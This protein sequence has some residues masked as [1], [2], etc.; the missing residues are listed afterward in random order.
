MGTESG[1]VQCGARGLEVQDYDSMESGGGGVGGL[2]PQPWRK[3]A[4]AE[5]S[6][7]S[8]SSSASASSSS[9]SSLSSPS[10]SPSNPPS[11]DVT[12]KAGTFSSPPILIMLLFLIVGQML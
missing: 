6:P 1:T 3:D 5:N 8:P 7:S 4:A 10:S 12:G 2:Q 9:S 11:K